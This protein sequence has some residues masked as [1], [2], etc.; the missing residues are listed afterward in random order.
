MKRSGQKIILIKLIIMKTSNKIIM[1]AA[2]VV[3]AW[4]VIYDNALKAE[5]VKGD[6]KKPHYRMQQLNFSNFNVIE[7]N[8]GNIIGMQVKKAPYGVWIDDYA[9][10]KIRVSR[11]GQT[12]QIDYIG[13]E[14]FNDYRGITI[15]CP[16]VT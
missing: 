15:S 13:K 2:L 12:L 7:H 10:D 4:L 16:D 8:A 5:Y 3:I 11:H 9:K 14:N 1:I 6:F